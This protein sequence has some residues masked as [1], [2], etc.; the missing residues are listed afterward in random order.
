L[1]YHH[2]QKEPDVGICLCRSCNDDINGGAC[3]TNVDWQARKLG[4][5]NKHNLQILKLA[6]REHVAEPA[7]SLDTF[8]TRLVE[9]YNL[10]QTTAAVRTIIEQARESDEIQSVI[11]YELPDYLTR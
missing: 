9:R 4:L 5:N 1:D 11:D 6:A 7:P 8:A 10:I 2:W 3:D